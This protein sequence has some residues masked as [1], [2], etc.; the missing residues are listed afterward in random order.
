[1]KY[2]RSQVLVLSCLWLC[3]AIG[4]TVALAA[5]GAR[6]GESGAPPAL[7]PRNTHIHPAG[8]HPTIL[9]FLHPR[10]PCSRSTIRELQR[11][12]AGA[13]VPFALH[14][15]VFSPGSERAEWSNTGVVRDAACLPGATV[16]FDQDG[17]ETARFGVRTSGHIL[18]YSDRGR[19]VFSGGVTQG[20]GH[21]GDNAGMDAVWGVVHGKAPSVCDTAVYGCSIFD[22]SG[23][24]IDPDG[25]C[26][27]EGQPCH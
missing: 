25:V 21:E 10:C 9:L 4:G 12:L 19:L 2:R 6:A 11:S 5:Y 13:S 8:T 26:P 23:A 27:E 14:L 16:L 18:V 20:R 3:L 15:I 1:V 7:W 24:C 22:D 17:E